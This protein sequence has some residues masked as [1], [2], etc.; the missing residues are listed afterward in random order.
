MA[1]NSIPSLRRTGWALLA[2]T[3]L[4]LVAAFITKYFG[5]FPLPTDPLEQLTLIATDSFGWPAQ[6]ILFPLCHVAVA[7][8]FGLLAA[9]LPQGLPRW[10]GMA[11]ALLFGIGALLW[12]PISLD[13]LRLFREAPELIRLYNPASPPVVFNDTGVF[14]FHTIAILAAIGHL[15][16]AIFFYW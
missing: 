10:L 2:A 4:F 13:R 11:A 7:V 15:L 6:A 5:R 16:S 1:D 14:W 12:L 9:R 8:V 3:L